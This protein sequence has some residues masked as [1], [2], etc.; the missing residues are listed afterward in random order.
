[1]LLFYKILFHI[2]IIWNEWEEINLGVC[3][4]FLEEIKWLFGA[5]DKFNWV[6]LIDFDALLDKRYIFLGR[7][8]LTK[9][10]R[11]LVSGLKHLNYLTDGVTL[12]CFIFVFRLKEIAA[13]SPWFWDNRRVNGMIIN[14]NSNGYQRVSYE[15][16]H[17][18]SQCSEL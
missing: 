10:S 3:I 11:L 9:I 15:T 4:I 2:F 16:I 13:R 12:K 8:C 17:L 1:M 18:S 6:F 14:M 5:Y 7:K